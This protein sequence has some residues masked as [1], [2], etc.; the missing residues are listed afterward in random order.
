MLQ[1]SI[2]KLEA[3][4]DKVL[5]LTYE[6]GEIKRF[7]VKPYISG[8]W[9]SLLNDAAYFNTVH[10]IDSG[11]GIAWEGGQDIAPH[12]LYDLSIPE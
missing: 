3:L 5:R 7:D 1:P 6:T 12:E 8:A 2:V 10:I 4:E 9:Y 11:R